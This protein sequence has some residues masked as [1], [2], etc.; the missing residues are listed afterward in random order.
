MS[1]ILNPVQ[2]EK[3]IRELTPYKF[4]KQTLK[5]G[6]E[7]YNFTMRECPN[8]MYEVARLRELSFRSAGCGTGN[9]IDIDD[10]DINSPSYNQLI[11][12][13][14]RELEIIGG[15]RYAVCSDYLNDVSRLSMSHYFR[16]SKGFINNYLP[17]ALE[18]GRAWVNPDYQSYSGNRK[19]I[20]ALDNLWDGIGTVLR[21]HNHVKYLYGKLTIPENYNDIARYL[22]HWV[23]NHYFRDNQGLINPEEKVT[24]P[25]VLNVAGDN[26]YKNDFKKDFRIIAQYIRDLGY[27]VPPLITAY[28]GIAGKI[29]TFGTT[30]NPELNNS[31]ETGLM[32]DIKDVYPD[33][34]ERYV[35]CSQLNK[36]I[37]A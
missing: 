15:Y 30:L 33:K 13:N 11:V 32:I 4:L 25:D 37:A 24:I 6:N 20:F 21:K 35:Y 2:R 8:L 19:S 3:L 14:P 36:L 31:F 9:I 16:F 10:Y 18:L 1:N 22:L 23:L 34:L 5:G 28:T 12:W 27:T 29:T 7:I 26:L 17:Y